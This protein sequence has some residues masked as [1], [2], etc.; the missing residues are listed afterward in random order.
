MG[1]ATF[2]GFPE[3]KLGAVLTLCTKLDALRI[4]DS[5][6]C[7]LFVKVTSVH[8]CLRDSNGC[9]LDFAGKTPMTI[10][11]D[12]NMFGLIPSLRVMSNLY[13]VGH[14]LVCHYSFGSLP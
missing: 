3:V 6:Y 12:C 1:L 9:N 11:L 8:F 13:V 5:E 10:S 2:H 14:C 4:R 7:E